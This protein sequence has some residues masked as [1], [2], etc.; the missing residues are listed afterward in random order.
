MGKMAGP[1]RFMF[2]CTTKHYTQLI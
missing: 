1:A 2:A